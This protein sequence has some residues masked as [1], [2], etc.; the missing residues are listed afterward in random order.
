M[1]I[2]S[3]KAVGF[4]SFADKVEFDLGKGQISA[5]VGPNGSGKSN[6][7][8]ALLW[9]LGEQSVKQLRGDNAMS[10]VIF[11][12]SKTREE[13]KKASVAITFN[14]ED[15]VLNT[16]F[17]E[18]EIKRTIYRTGENEYFINDA[19]VRLKDITDLF[20][21]VASKFNI[22][23]QGNIS[24]LVENKSSERRTL[25][26][27]AAGVLKYKK[28]KEESLKKLDGTKENL[29]RINLIINELNTTLEPLKEQKEVASKYMEYKTELEKVEVSLLAS[30]ITSFNNNLSKLKNNNNDYSKRLETMPLEKPETI[31]KLKLELVKTDEEIN[32]ISN[33]IL[34]LSNKIAGLNSQKKINMERISFNIDKGKIDQKLI[35]LNDTKFD[36]ERKRDV[37]DKE[38]NDLKKNL[39]SLVKEYNESSDKELKL[40]VT[41]TNNNNDLNSVSKNILEIQNKIDIEN[42]NS[43][44]NSYL[45]KSVSSVLNNPRLTG[46]HQTIKNVLDINDAHYIAISSALGLSAN[47]I[48]CDSLNDAK[49]AINYLK[50]NNI[51]KA[52]FFPIDTIK[53]RK[54]DYVTIDEI[55]SN[56]GFIGVAS[57]LVSFDEKYRSIIENQL[58]NVIIAEDMDSMFKLAKDTNYRFKLVSLEGEVLFPGGSISGGTN[59]YKD[60]KNVLVNL[61][62]ELSS[63]KEKRESIEFTLNNNTDEYNKL[64][65]KNNDIN[66]KIIDLRLLIEG[67]E[68]SLI[69]YKEKLDAVYSDIK[70]MD[71][72]DKGKIDDTINKITE[73]INE[74]QKNKD[75]KE[76]ELRSLQSKKFDI[77]NEINSLEVEYQKQNSEYHDLENKI[78]NNEVEIARL[79]IKIDN[80]IAI[81]TNDYNLTYDHVI[82]NYDTDIDINTSRSIVSK[83]K[84]ELKKFGEV[85]IGSIAEYDRLKKRYDFLDKQRSDLEVSSGEL[86]KIIEEMDDIMKKRFKEAFDKI[87]T[88]FTKVFRVMFKGGNGLLKLSDEN[89]LLNTNINILAVPPGKKLNSIT[90][91]S[92]GEKALTAICLIFAILNVKPAP[93]VVLDEAEAALDEENVNMFGDYLS[94]MKSQSQFIII[95]HKKK[96]MEYA[97][98]LYGITIQESGVS[99]LVSVKL[100]NE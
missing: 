59:S 40:K 26:E 54:I 56:K 39:S 100:D 48:I 66:K 27:N 17:K 62:N 80:D 72:L 90:A 45:P 53:S 73:D 44:N 76:N 43:E 20:L 3:I 81:L 88:E 77:N 94:N 11:M 8:D 5:I 87:S 98:T 67:K 46:I 89:D 7:V 22:I 97:D 95:T 36:L 2:K 15:H 79:E 4:K 16:D 93:F 82:N 51:G 71:D 12:G 19:R 49:K 1:Y 6:I 14:N 10:D 99:K 37:I 31:E 78:K 65:E 30:E 68:W 50:D 21:D 57:D 47:F 9:C 41:I 52:T 70:G 13:A 64:V 58:G 96:M 25:F 24:A 84:N 61:K 55:K 34:D 74:S 18:V 42:N 60:S 83:L 75:I 33:E 28:R 92:G 38:V 86:L 23:T 29:T 63:L 35:E 85:N 69:E 91:L 32:K